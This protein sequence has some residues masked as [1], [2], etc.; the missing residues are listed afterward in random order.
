MS[1]ASLIVVVASTVGA[2]DPG[3]YRLDVEVVALASVPVMG[4]QRTVTK[5][6]S[7]LEVDEHGIATA[8]ACRVETRGPGFSSRMPP[9]S[10]RGL[11]A[12]RFALWQEGSTVRAD[13]GEGAI[14]YRGAGPVPSSPDDPRV[15]D[16]DGDG[17]PGLQLLLDVGAFGVWTLQVVSRGHTALE[18]TVTP[19]G[20]VGT[21]TRVESEEQVI[22]GLPVKLPSRTTAIDPRACRFTITPVR[23]GDESFCA[24]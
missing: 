7:L 17:K 21:L 8:R 2:V 11:P 20:I 6:T 16:P 22:S 23:R 10:L 15:V 12:S 9:T 14:G 18:G 4:A 19:T 1:V 5:T 24:W 13:M 3:L